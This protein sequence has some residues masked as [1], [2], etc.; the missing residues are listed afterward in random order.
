MKRISASDQPE[1]KKT[2]NLLHLRY[3]E[4]FGD[5]EATANPGA[6]TAYE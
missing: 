3:P 4:I 5:L 6:I 2:S 1:S